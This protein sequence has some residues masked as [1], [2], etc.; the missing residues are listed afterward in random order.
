LVIKDIWRL[1]ADDNI[2]VPDLG[3]LSV[4][5]HAMPNHFDVLHPLKVKTHTIR[6]VLNYVRYLSNEHGHTQSQQGF[7]P[8]D[9]AFHGRITEPARRRVSSMMGCPDPLAHIWCAALDVL[10]PCTNWMRVHVCLYGTTPTTRAATAAQERIASPT[11]LSDV[12]TD[13]SFSVPV[14]QVGGG[15]ESIVVE[16]EDAGVVGRIVR[17]SQQ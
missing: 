1:H 9:T 13:V 16:G 4:N 7:R 3:L 6:S 17:A 8:P 12:L 11:E 2:Q 10:T 14:M 15:W 5:G